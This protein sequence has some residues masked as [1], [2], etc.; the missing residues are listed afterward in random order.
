MLGIREEKSN[1]V[2]TVCTKHQNPAPFKQVNALTKD[3]EKNPF[4]SEGY[5]SLGNGHDVP[6]YISRDIGATQSLLV[7]GILPLSKETATWSPS[8]V[9]LGIISVLKSDQEKLSWVFVPL[10]V[11]TLQKTDIY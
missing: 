11:V 5:V 7:E 1:P 6:I 2:S 9:E 10:S 3:E 4:I 8:F